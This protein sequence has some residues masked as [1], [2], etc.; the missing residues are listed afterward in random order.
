MLKTELN[1]KKGLGT[2]DDSPETPIT[3]PN[4]NE[5]SITHFATDEELTEKY[6]TPENMRAELNK[7]EEAEE[8]EKAPAPRKTNV[9]TAIEMMTE[10]YT[11]IQD[12]KDKNNLFIEVEDA[13]TGFKRVIG[14]RSEEFRLIIQRDYFLQKKKTM[15]DAASREAQSLFASLALDSEKRIPITIKKGILGQ[16]SIT[17]D[18]DDPQ[19]IRVY[20]DLG[21][22]D[23]NKCVLIQGDRKPEVLEE[24]PSGI[25]FLRGA[26]LKSLPT[27]DFENASYEGLWKAMSLTGSDEKL[28]L[29][30]RPWLAQVFFSHI[31]R[32]FIALTGYQNT[33][34]TTAA[35]ML[36][37]L[38]DPR[39]HHT[40]PGLPPIGGASPS[41]E[42]LQ[43]QAVNRFVMGLDNLS[44]LDEK[45]QNVLANIGTGGTM[46]G[47]ALYTPTELYVAEM[48]A[49]AIMTAINVKVRSDLL[50]RVMFLDKGEIS[51]EMRT[52]NEDYEKQFKDT[53]GAVLAA[54]FMDAHAI[55]ANSGM[56]VKA[57]KI[58]RQTKYF[59]NIQRLEGQVD[60]PMAKAIVDNQIE[61]AQEAANNDPF[62]ILVSEFL[63]ASA[64]E[65]V[66][67]KDLKPDK[68]GNYIVQ[69]EH[70]WKDLLKAWQDGTTKFTSDDPSLVETKVMERRGDLLEVGID[71]RKDL[72]HRGTKRRR[73]FDVNFGKNDP[74]DPQE[75]SE[76]LNEAMA[77][78]K[79]KSESVWDSPEAPFGNGPYGGNSH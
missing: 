72:G 65:K 73:F 15:S 68:K 20:I 58:V 37:S 5:F 32:P 28:K 43:V 42:S 1:A 2:T 10:T 63:K 64:L 29:L 55:L 60:G 78:T 6:G 3:I 61:K 9:E 34:K 24:P 40:V 49:V 7:A 25:Y 45:T 46:E 54:M 8:E 52:V 16:R 75:L 62:V 76:A 33:G 69:V 26:I 53:Q 31:N 41:I 30:L 23:N 14:I 79:A 48:K 18:Q 35:S 50:S 22:E 44:R 38:T 77:E 17:T 56:E 19:K 12:Q 11:V 51:D 59:G 74:N 47:R 21:Q 67:G 66:K 27:P 39:E 70:P 4:D 13:E 57:N 71:Y 36:M